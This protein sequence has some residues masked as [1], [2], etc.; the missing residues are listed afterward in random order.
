MAEEFDSSESLDNGSRF[1]HYRPSGSN[2]MKYLIRFVIAL[3]VLVLLIFIGRQIHHYFFVDDKNTKPAP[4]TTSTTGP[5]TEAT[6]NRPSG[7]SSSSTSNRRSS[8]STTAS[9]PNNGPGDVLAIFVGAV[10]L[11]GGLHFWLTARRQAASR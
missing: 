7:S 9:L 10:V 1:Q 3:V 6:T 5:G 2:L 11:S 8:S 4:T